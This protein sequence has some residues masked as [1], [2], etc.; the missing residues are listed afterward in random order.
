MFV[1]LRIH[2]EFSVVD[3]TNRI[4]E[5]VAAA[6]AD[7]QPA[8]AITDLSNLFGTVKFYKEGRKTGVKPLIGADIW[9]EAP[10][11]EAGAP[12]SRLLL[13]VQD[14]QGYLNLCELIT[15]AWTK[16]V[17]RDQAVVKLQWLQELN[18]GLI[19]LSGAQ[20]G[21]VGQALVQGDSARAMECALHLSG[22]FPR[23][24]YLELQRSGH[25]EDER[26]VTAAV[27][28]AARLKLPV[29]ATHPVQFLTYDDY[30]AHE[31]RVC[32]SEGEILG[33]A[34]RVRKFTREQYFKS[35]DQMKALFADV[36]SALANTVE[37]AKRCSLTLELG[38]PMLPEFPTPEVNGSR[39]PPE[40]YFRHTSFEG[41]EER[42]L[43]LYP[44]PAQRD[45]KRPEYVARLEFEINT[46]LK[47]GFPGYFLIV[48]DFIQ[49]AKN[50]GCPVGPGR[51]SGAGSLVAYALKITDLDPLRYNLLFERFLNPERVSMPDFDIDFCQS[52]R[53]RVIDYVKDKYGHAAVSQIV[54]FGT[55]A[56]RAAIRDVGR[57]LDFPYGFCDGISKLI[58]N[59][60]GQ[61]VTLQLVPADRKKNDKMVYALE[62][63]PVLADRESKEED[64]HTLLDL[65]RKLEGLTRNVGMHAGGVLIAPGK[66]TDFCPLYL[67]PGSTSAVS[68]FDKNDVEAIGLVKFDFLGLA[69]LTILEIAREF[70]I[71]RYPAQKDFKFE[72]L[73]LDDARVYRLFAD[74]NTEAVFQFESIGMQR[75]LKDARP[76]R[77]EDLIAMNALY[78]PG[79][80]DL[81]P[82]YI[83]RKQG[84]EVPEYPDPRVKPMLEETYGIM[85]YQEQVMQTAQIL[86][87]YSLGGADML[88]RAM[89]KKD[90][91]EMAQHREIFRKGAGI[92]GLAQEKADEVFDL[93]EKFAG[94][95][96]NKSHSAAYA[97]LAYHTA[98]LKVHFPAEFFAANMTVEMDDT[99]KLKILFGDAQKMGLSFEVPDINQGDYRFEPITAKSVRYGLGAIK[100]TGQQAIAAIVAARKE[101]GPFT[102][103]FDF[104][105]RVD[106]SKMNKRTVEALIKGGAFDSL[107]LNRAE[108]LASSERAF[109]FAAA[110]QAN[111]NQGGLFDMSDSHAASTQEPELVEMP[112]FG[113]KA[114]L[115]LEKTA[116]GFYLSGH[117]FD[118]VEQEVRQFAKR[119]IEDMS[120]SR[121]SQ[122]LAGI[123]TDLRIINGNRGKLIIFKL[124]DKT[125]VLEVSVDEATFNANR[126][127][128]KEDELVIVQG[129]LQGASERFGRRF[130]ITQVWDLES[131]RCRFGKYL[132]VAVNG[133][134]PDISKLVRDFPPRSS[135]A[136]DPSEPV[137]GLPV[138]LS[139]RR[140]TAT[141]EL[142][143]GDAA[144]FFPTDAALAS[145]MAQAD[146]GLARIVYE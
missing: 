7:Q 142:H 119:S 103:L 116:I 106:R 54:T 45:A 102:S 10:G 67:Q 6:A 58:P 146:K 127:L 16:N 136:A 56:A 121:D 78:R 77:L 65:A 139:L 37:I 138:R 110:T 13:L 135:E 73:P 132:R 82:T 137:R 3:G 34:R 48:G 20:R 41:L 99:D 145:W 32:I 112:M 52:N 140:E 63:E 128:L 100:G 123:V 133:K 66:L 71:A 75:M 40:D 95:G 89:G 25:P 60:P 2:T 143:L 9:L 47:M 14:S 68:Q 125:D 46:I 108:L 64:V 117:L 62:A 144:R 85:V 27:Q 57:V 26:H 141:A 23:R 61:A 21:A 35:A 55:M 39:M 24:F 97:L 76:D 31:A 81:I 113:V 1:H 69:T 126:N 134:A 118:E 87:G 28:L 79:P 130:K 53:D 115:V 131:A 59:K 88:R 4:D 18:E 43:H 49:W 33:N 80:M 92:N 96:F 84:K 101:G 93:M 90:E 111:A 50:N 86:G 114:R 17:V 72:D 12:A 44:N 124:D 29:V 109:D 38:K 94:Y 19:A 11:K 15:R 91:K 8:L 120:E 98:W 51:G 70:I 105:V 104:C 5:I 122:L 129:T 107:H 74:G 36:P 22:M 42:L 30:E 83:A